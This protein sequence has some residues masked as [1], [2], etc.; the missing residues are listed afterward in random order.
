MSVYNLTVYEAGQPNNAYCF[1][2]TENNGNKGSCEIGT[3]ILEWVK[4]IP[5]NVTEISLFSDTCGGQNR[6]QF[7]ASLFLYI[8]Q[9][10]N[11]INVIEHKFMEKGH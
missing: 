8:T 10:F 3:A 9:T 2:W 11:N 5:D 4:T 6:Y 7:I 1:T